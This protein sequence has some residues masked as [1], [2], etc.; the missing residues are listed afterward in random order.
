MDGQLLEAMGRAIEVGGLPGPV[1]IVDTREIVRVRVPVGA[2]AKWARYFDREP[3]RVTGRDE[4]G[5]L[6]YP[7]MMVHLTGALLVICEDDMPAV[8]AG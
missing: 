1:S 6:A 8:E 2:L 3:V 5:H 4:R 7:Q